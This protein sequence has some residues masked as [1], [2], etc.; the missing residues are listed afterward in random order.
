MAVIIL[1]PV[2]CAICGSM[3]NRHEDE[4]TKVS[5]GYVHRECDSEQNQEKE[6]RMELNKMLADIFGENLNFGIIGQQIKNYKAQYNYTLSGIMGTLYYCY[7]VLGMD[8]GKAQGIGIVPYYYKEARSY[9]GAIQNARDNLGRL[10]PKT[11]V[12]HISAPKA[13]PIVKFRELSLDYL[14]EEGS[15]E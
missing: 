8:P 12:V 10:E 6:T 13:E 1:R 3:I 7:T 14:E 5:K 15:S 9:F 2:K 11:K 4:Y